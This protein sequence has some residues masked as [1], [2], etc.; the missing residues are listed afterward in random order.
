LIKKEN[1]PM[2]L[3]K[4]QE[5]LLPLLWKSVPELWSLS[6]YLCSEALSPAASVSSS[7]VNSPQCSPANGCL[8]S[9]VFMKISA[10]HRKKQE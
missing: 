1:I 3:K 4:K 2:N 8:H 9:M 10:L 6:P 7:E 5:K